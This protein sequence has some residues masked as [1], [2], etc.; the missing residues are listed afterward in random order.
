MFTAKNGKK[1]GSAFAGKRY[2]ENH[3]EDG[4]HMMGEAHEKQ[5]MEGE[6][7][8]PFDAETPEEDNKESRTDEEGEGKN[9]DADK[10]EDTDMHP[11]TAEHGK[12]HK[13]IIHHDEKA[14]KHHVTSYHKDGHENHSDHENAA[15]AHAEG[16]K[17]A[18]VPADGQAKDHDSPYH[19]GKP[20]AGASSEE[21]GFAMPDLA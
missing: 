11:V 13:V 21:D 7:N 18:G 10:S 15:E 6:G 8:K 19:Q 1:F 12:A 3:S 20:Q 17:L 14:G 16:N 5:D 9:A 2:D 4:M